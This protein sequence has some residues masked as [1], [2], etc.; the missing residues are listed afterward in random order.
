MKVLIA[1]DDPV[2][3][4]LL[5]KSLTGWGYE[6]V[7]CEDGQQAWGV[8]QGQDAP[9]MAVVDWMMPGMDG[10]DLCRK[11][12]N[13]EA[14]P[15]KY[16]IL[17]TVKGRKDELLEGLEAGADDY[18]VKPFDPN[19]LRVRIGGGARLVRL[20]EQLGE[21]IQ[22]RR[23]AE[24]RLQRA[25]DQLE[26]RVEER[27]SEL[28]QA[29]E[30]LLREIAERKKTEELLSASLREKEVLLQE[31]HHRVKNNLQIVSSLLALQCAYFE[32]ARILEALEDSQSRVRSM[33]LI[34]EQLYQSQDLA[35]I[36]FSDY[37]KKL[38][39]SLK[40]S[41]SHLAAT[42]SL[43]VAADGI[44]LSIG[45]AITCGLII[46]E[47]VSNGLK[48][49]F[50]QGQEGRIRVEVRSG[51]ESQYTLDVA[52]NGRGLPP[53]LDHRA[54]KS[55]GLRLVTRLAEQQLHGRLDVETGNGTRFRIDFEDRDSR[56]EGV[57]Q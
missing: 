53:G 39:S 14:Q 29:N 15:Y 22:I 46:N 49:A 56:L 44:F 4:L 40:R 16:V 23:E 31:I 41:L 54:S 2:I 33:A 5:E 47:L 3:R 13:A 25:H 45:T 35:R 10:V 34:H 21:E 18:I 36:D 28:C 6:V 57:Y 52:D 42:I 8:L 9:K 32:D 38:I 48:H 43:E 27:T 1:E 30:R 19:E 24:R 12:R 51:G 50:A 11:I 26:K 20:Q 55:L 37:L 17:L 7:S